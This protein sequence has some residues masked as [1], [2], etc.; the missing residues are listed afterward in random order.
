MRDIAT[1]SKAKQ[2]LL[3]R[4]LSSGASGAHPLSHGQERLW[5]LEQLRPG[6]H[7]YNIPIAARFTGRL[8][9]SAAER[10]INEVIRRHDSLRTVFVAIAG[11]PFQIVRADAAITLTVI[12]RAQ[13][14]GAQRDPA[15]VAGAEDDD[16][17]RAFVTREA[18]APFTLSEAPLLRA[19]LLRL[20]PERHVLVLILHHIIADGWSL[21]VLGREIATLYTDLVSGREPSLPP[22]ALQYP[23]VS[24]QQRKALRGPRLSALLSYWGEQ[25]RGSEELLPLPTD[26][27][28]PAVQAFRGVR[29]LVPMSAALTAAVRALCENQGVTLFMATMA[30]FQLLLHRY[31]AGDDIVVGTP[32]ANR[33]RVETEALIGFFVNM[34]VM[35]T[36][37]AGDPPFTELLR[38]ARRTALG[39]YDH[40]DLPFEVLV[41]E[42]QP[43]RFLSHQPIFQVMFALQNTPLEPVRLPGVTMEPIEVD[44]GTAKFDLSLSIAARGDGLVQVWEYDSELF[45]DATIDRMA[46]HYGNVL[47]AV[48]AEPALP[49]SRVPVLS[50]SEREQITQGWNR[51]ESAFDES[52]CAHQRFEAQ[53][54]ATPDAVAATSEGAHL[55][56]AAL[57]RRCNRL[58]HLLRQRGVA[59][60]DMVGVFLDRS[61]EMLVALFAIHKAGGAYVPL[62]PADPPARLAFML[63]DTGVD[64]VV[65]TRERAPALPAGAAEVVCVDAEDELAAYD[66]R[67]PVVTRVLLAGEALP[68]ELLLRL[69]RTSQAALYN[70]Y[71]PTEASVYATWW[72]CPDDWQGGP[73]PIGRPLPNVTALVLDR[74]G[75]PVPQGVPGELHIGG[76]GLARGYLNDPETSDEKFIASP[77][78]TGER[79]YRT[80]DVVRYLPGGDIEFLGRVDHQVKVRGVRIELGEIEAVLAAS[81]A[82]KQVTATVV[83]R[84]GGDKQLAA[85]V[86][87]GADLSSLTQEQVGFGHLIDTWRS[88]WAETYSGASAAAG[89]PELNT[90]GW[91][92]SFTGEPIP[93]AEM[94]DWLDATVARI[95]ALRPRRILEIGCGTG[96][97]LL[98]LAPGCETYVGTDFS[99]QV[100]SDLGAVV[101][102]R[103]LPGVRLMCRGADDLSGLDDAGFDVIIL[104]SV[105][106]YFPGP[107][108]LATVLQG[109]ARLVADGGAIFVGDVR[110]RALLEA[111]HTALRLGRA[112]DAHAHEVRAL[113]AQAVREEREL[114]VSPAWFD[115][116]AARTPRMQRVHAEP[117]AGRN[118]NELEHYR[119]DAVIHVGTAAAE[120]LAPAWREL[121]DD[122]QPLASLRAALEDGEGAIGVR[123]LVN[124]RL[125]TEVVAWEAIGAV[126]EPRPVAELVSEAQARAEARRARAVHPEDV[127]AL[128]REL[129][130][131]CQLSLRRGARDGSYDAA[132]Y[133]LDPGH[134]DQAPPAIAFDTAVA[135]AGADLSSAPQRAAAL[136]RLVP[137]L[138]AR[139]RAE[140][141][142]YMLPS[143]IVVLDELP[144]TPSG[145]VDR[146]LL[147][148]MTTA[149]SARARYAPPRTA[150]ERQVCQIWQ[151]LL[152][153][154]RVGIDDKFFEIGGDSLTVVRLYHK[155]DQEFP[156]RFSVALL[157]DHSTVRSIC[158]LVSD[159]DDGGASGEAV[160][161]IEL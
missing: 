3:A 46:E 127:Y 29:R 25:M 131:G 1:L 121:G 149:H 36:S 40:Q 88:V 118:H 156:G 138:R 136:H 91:R 101:A 147:P 74:Y 43:R 115:D 73:V 155:L 84:V 83:E 7:S 10:A 20:A 64:V 30:A 60:G 107:A 69:R 54:R 65:S 72:R 145:K 70:V 63:R 90:V 117:K 26:H 48:C 122:A 24:A 66:E 68:A 23:Q 137:T 152:R 38:R 103:A 114:A 21:G 161:G 79:L 4:L 82:V 128:A 130:W 51:T 98:R 141:P 85:Y 34:L 44:N 109:A 9:V 47:S 148:T 22:L 13:L 140:L 61:V 143:S 71:G 133:R 157:F 32:V 55:S 67:A 100:V 119:Y 17:V 99:S 27:P 15:A 81:P 134:V 126:T 53:A 39:A 78:G 129:G 146:A 104:N 33:T 110:S 87:P 112:E 154:E 31:G 151:E 125:L 160:E 50:A 123:G 95:R 42:L 92:S 153:L 97:L 57:D 49:V 124:P 76:K 41:R 93:Q 75:A 35:R 56:Y 28:R 12:D 2:V 132:F 14:G 106:Q 6:H 159:D 135:D 105:I 37:C 80:G 142:S 45:E 5:Y 144:L 58:A 62:D 59:R 150:L 16:V 86:V 102:Q 111:F 139:L 108:Y 116:L 77:L 113:V 158:A 18:Q 89:D 11:E 94:R 8:D 52:L 19:K 96:M 120:A